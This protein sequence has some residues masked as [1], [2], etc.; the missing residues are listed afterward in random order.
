MASL[1]IPW[2]LLLSCLEPGSNTLLIF[3]EKRKDMV[4]LLFYLVRASLA[5]A[6]MEH[7]AT[8]VGYN[9]ATARTPPM[10]QR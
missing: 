8:S 7:S 10:P 9:G 5:L 1:Q 3:I 4:H 2:D 6:T